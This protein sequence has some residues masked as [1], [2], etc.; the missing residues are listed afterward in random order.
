MGS[1]CKLYSSMQVMTMEAASR[2]PR[3]GL[4]TQDQELATGLN[5]SVHGRSLFSKQR[6]A[7]VGRGGAGGGD[8]ASSHTLTGGDTYPWLCA[9]VGVCS[10]QE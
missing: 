5:Q 10:Y 2:G 4:S 8:R 7:R 1:Q 6:G 3:V 9:W